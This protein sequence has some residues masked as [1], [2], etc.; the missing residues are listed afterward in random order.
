MDKI[1]LVTITYNSAEVLKL[2]LDCVWAQTHKNII[3][4]V[5]DNSSS[6]STLEILS[7][8]SDERLVVIENDTNFDGKV[9]HW[10]FFDSS[11]KLIRKESDR[12]FDGKPDLVEN[13]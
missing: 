11:E 6:D 4:Y 3:L 2:F 8:D 13:Q 12:N 5:V 7:A 9:D 1:G 10:E